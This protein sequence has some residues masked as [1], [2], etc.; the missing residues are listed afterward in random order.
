MLQKEY[1]ISKYNIINVGDELDHY[2]GSH[3]PKDPEARLSALDEIDA[4]K[5]ILREWYRAFPYMHIATS[6]HGQRW[7]KKAVQAEIPSQLLKSYQEIIEAPDT[8]RWKDEWVFKAKNKTFR[9]IHGSEYSGVSGARN[10]A[11]DSKISTVLGHIHS[12][13]GVVHIKTNGYSEQIWAMNVGCLIDTKQFAFQ[14]SR[15]NRNQAT[16]GCG[17]ILDG[18]KTPIFVPFE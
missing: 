16:L 4:S 14:Y 2:F 12:H 6:N 15:A 8:W 11:I 9:V 1:N 10:A 17:V 3:Y 18:G 13:A 5:R 7:V